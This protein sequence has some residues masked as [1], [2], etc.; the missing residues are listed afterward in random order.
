MTSRGGQVPPP[1][2]TSSSGGPGLGSADDGE[3]TY[4]QRGGGEER[5]QPTREL[6]PSVTHDVVLCEADEPDTQLTDGVLTPLLPP[7]DLAR[8][9]PVPWVGVLDAPVELHRQRRLVEPGVHTREESVG[10]VQ[11]DLEFR[12]RETSSQQGEA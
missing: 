1:H 6:T 10:P 8:I 5:C 12:P 7:E 4:A 2:P 11:L 9:A 3:P